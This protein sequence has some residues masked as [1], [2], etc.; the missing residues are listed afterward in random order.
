KRPAWRV[1]GVIFALGALATIPALALNL[2]GQGLFMDFF[3]VT[4]RSRIL[5]LLFVIGPVEELLKLL[6]VY[7][8]AYRRKEFDEPLDGVIFSATAALGFAAVENV[9]Y[10]ARN[11][12]TLVLLRGP[13]SNPGHALFSALWALSRSNAKAS[14]DLSRERAPIGARG[15]LLAS[16]LHSLFD[17]SLLAAAEL[18]K[19]FFGLLIAMMVA[20]FF[21]AR[22]RIKFHTDTSPHREGTLQMTLSRYCQ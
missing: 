5:T 20:L 10:L 8:Y 2:A 1:L 17:L 14:P 16:L 18:N 12:P 4:Q 6:V 7:F 3:G 13:L 19:S 22:S 21:W 15:F 11:D 9:I